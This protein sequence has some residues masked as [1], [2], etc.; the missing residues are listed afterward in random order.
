MRD[1][2]TNE[3]ARR[4]VGL[5][6]A[7]DHRLF[8]YILSLVPNFADAEELAQQVRL[9]LWE[10]FDDYDPERNFGAWTRT[11]AYYLVL[12]HYKSSTSRRRV[13]LSDRTLELIA[14]EAAAAAEQES[15]VLWAMQECLGRLDE[16]KRQLLMRYY[17]S[18]DTLQQIASQ[19][20]RSLHAVRHSVSRTRVALAGC[21]ERTLRREGAFDAK[22]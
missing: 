8:A 15:D 16:S 21:I 10:Q 9:R 5:M 12:A 4:F 1:S 19:I 17:S 2:A 18:N 20:G 14:Q 11:I 22:P 6:G 3:R 7:H 13:L